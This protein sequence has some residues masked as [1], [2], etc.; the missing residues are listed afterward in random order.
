MTEEEQKAKVEVEASKLKAQEEDLEKD[1]DAEEL[2]NLK[3]EMKQGVTREDT[4]G[5]DI[6]KA[7]LLETGEIKLGNGKM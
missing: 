7:E 3:F 1:R 6:K 5:L 2:A 4:L